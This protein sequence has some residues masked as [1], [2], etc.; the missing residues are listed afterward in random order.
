MYKALHNDITI[1]ESSIHGL[2]VFAIKD[3]AKDII[4]GISH[5]KDKNNPSCHH[6]GYIRTPL[7]GFINH[8]PQPN[9]I[10]VHPRS[11]IPSH[12]WVIIKEGDEFTSMAI[13]TSRDIKGGEELTVF[14]TFYKVD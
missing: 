11:W 2:G 4:L 5:V 14:Y 1:K 3:I 9:C 8:S 6:K 13:R 10:K 12:Q 7:G